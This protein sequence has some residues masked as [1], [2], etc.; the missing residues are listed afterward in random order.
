MSAHAWVAAIISL[1]GP[2][3]LRVT[4]TPQTTEAGAGWFGEATGEDGRVIAR[5]WRPTADGAALDALAR[6]LLR[7]RATLVSLTR[8][9]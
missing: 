4:A 8:E 2:E 9:S 7:H 5:E 6:Y 1:D 3:A